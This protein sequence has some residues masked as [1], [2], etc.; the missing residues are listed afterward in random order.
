MSDKRSSSR[1][2]L[3]P[4]PARSHSALSGPQ[5][6]SLLGI[7]TELVLWL[8]LLWAHLPL[9]GCWWD[10]WWARLHGTDSRSLTF[11]T[12]LQTNSDYRMNS[13]YNFK[14]V[15]LKEDISSVH[16]I[17][18]KCA[19]GCT[20]VSTYMIQPEE[21]RPNGPNVGHVSELQVACEPTFGETCSLY[22]V[23]WEFHLTRQC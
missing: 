11:E 3:T 21:P 8:V 10:R 9:S 20:G 6:S 18:Y 22:V 17:V 4:N 2:Q 14:F 23:F 15:L 13:K 1:R 12:D 16:S 19:V 5:L 7:T